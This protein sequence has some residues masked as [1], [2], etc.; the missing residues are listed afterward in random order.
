[1][2]SRRSQYSGSSRLLRN[3][4]TSAGRSGPAGRWL[5]A[6]QTTTEQPAPD[7]LHLP[8]A[9][10]RLGSPGHSTCG[11]WCRSGVGLFAG[12]SGQAHSRPSPGQEQRTLSVRRQQ[13][14]GPLYDRRAGRQQSATGPGGISRG[15]T[16]SVPVYSPGK[17]EHCHAGLSGPGDP[18]DARPAL[19]SLPRGPAHRSARQDELRLPAAFRHFSVWQGTPACRVPIRTTHRI[20]V[21]FFRPGPKADRVRS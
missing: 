12:R 20:I 4:L 17:A 13:T 6:R 21:G 16:R 10:I 5:P 7:L 11:M 2:A 1:M 8:L 3:P 9:R 15:L 19:P 18:G 14:A